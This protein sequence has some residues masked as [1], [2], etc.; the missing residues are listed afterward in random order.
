MGA[1]QAPSSEE[2]WRTLPRLCPG[3]GSHPIALVV[4]AFCLLGKIK[5]SSD[6][7]LPSESQHKRANVTVEFTQ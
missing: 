3:C 1:E 5:L 2:P 4:L 6:L 7:I